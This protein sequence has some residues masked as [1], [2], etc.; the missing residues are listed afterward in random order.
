[1][2]IDTSA[3]IGAWPFGH[4][5]AR[6]AAELGRHLRSHGIARALVSHLGAVFAPDPMPANR[7]LFAETRRRP[8]LVPVPI[9]NPALAV[10]SEHLDE[11]CRLAPALRAVRIAPGYHDFQ[12]DSLRVSALC[13][14]LQERRVRLI[15][16]VRFVDLRLDYFALKIQSAGESA[17]HDFLRAH[18]R[19]QP[20]LSGLTLAELRTLQRL[21]GRFVADIPFVEWLYSIESLVAQGA[22]TRLMFGS[23]TPFFVTQANIAKLESALIPASARHAIGWRNAARFFS[24]PGA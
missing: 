23:Q 4:L 2:L 13:A 16:N 24:L 7:T 12:L 8:A 3:Y 6:S 1:M 20:L 21:G 17:L 14:A 9:L 18:P 15:V 22:Q 19:L 10:W 5:P 11:C